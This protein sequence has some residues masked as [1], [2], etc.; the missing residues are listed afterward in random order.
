M[1]FQRYWCRSWDVSVAPCG[2]IHLTAYAYSAYSVRVPMACKVPLMSTIDEDRAL[3]PMRFIR[4]FRNG[5]TVLGQVGKSYLLHCTGL[6]AG[7]RKYL[8][9]DMFECH[10]RIGSRGYCR[11]GRTSMEEGASTTNRRSWLPDCDPF[12]HSSILVRGR[13]IEISQHHDIGI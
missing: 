5:L 11:R 3:L 13:Y 6:T 9:F 4:R 7:G 1:L 10:F 2:L 12:R 8:E